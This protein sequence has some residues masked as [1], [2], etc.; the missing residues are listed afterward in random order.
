MKVVSRE[1]SSRPLH[2]VKDESFFNC[3]KQSE[4]DEVGERVMCGFIYFDHGRCRRL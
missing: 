3:P 4:G 2:E 1:V